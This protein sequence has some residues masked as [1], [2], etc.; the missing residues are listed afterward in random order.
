[1]VSDRIRYG[2]YL[3]PSPEMCAAQV[4]VHQLLE[5]QYGLRVAGKFMPHCTIKG[6][7]K[8]SAPEAD[9]RARAA[10][11]SEGL[12]SFPVWNN[13]VQGFGN[14][15][16]VL[17]ILDDSEGGRNESLQVLHE[18]ALDTLLPLIDD[19]CNFTPGEWNRERYDAHLTLAMADIEPRFFDE[20]LEFC[21]QLE[22]IGPELFPAERLHLYAFESDDWHGHWAKTL[23]WKL[24]ES[25]SIAHQ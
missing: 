18:R 8:S 14:Q 15:A 3:R 12:A 16:I 24:V 23:N 5:R 11:I 9:I 2:Y 22:P 21:R 19:D 1:M 10:T 17:S 20:I 6:F 13:R 7:F 25:W 4:H